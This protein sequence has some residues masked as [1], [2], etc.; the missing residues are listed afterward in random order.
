[1]RAGRNTQ[2]ALTYGDEPEGHIH[3]VD[4]AGA[5]PGDNH[6]V[7]PAR[8]LERTIAALGRKS[9]DCRCVRPG[10][11]AGLFRPSSQRE[12]LAAKASVFPPSE[13]TYLARQKFVMAT[14][15]RLHQEDGVAVIYPHQVLCR[16]GIYAL[17]R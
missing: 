13:D 1:M 9:G 15:T 12:K 8:G 4:G 16:S 10:K 3:L 2:R 5:A 11:S 6:G 7:F 17:S 14:F